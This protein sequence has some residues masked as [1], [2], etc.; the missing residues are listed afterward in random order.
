MHR[1]SLQVLLTSL[2]LAVCAG[3][4][5]ALAADCE[6][7]REV[8]LGLGREGR[9]AAAP[10]NIPE[11]CRH[12]FEHGLREGLA[13]YCQP[14]AGFQRGLS[15]QDEAGPC[16]DRAFRIEF[17]LGRQIRLLRAERSRLSRARPEELDAMRLRVVERELSQ[18]EGLARIRG[19]LPADPAASD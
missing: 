7:E 16:T 15:G 13:Q 6:A 1:V 12:A 3:G 9:P 8:G 18:I 10:E 4:Q 11:P 17:E 14:Q 5:Q 2:L 19:L